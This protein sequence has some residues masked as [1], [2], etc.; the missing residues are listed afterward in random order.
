VQSQTSGHPVE[1]PC[2]PVTNEFLTGKRADVSDSLN[3]PEQ[4]KLYTA[5]WRWHF[6]AGLLAVP[7][8]IFLGVTGAIY[9]FKPVAEPWLYRDLLT[10]EPGDTRLPVEEQLAAVTQ[11]FPESKP[12]SITVGVEPDDATEVG[13]RD[14][15]GQNLLV[16]VNPYSGEVTGSLVRDR[17]LMQQVRNLHGELMMGAFGSAFVE[18]TACWTIILMM[19]GLYLWWPRAGLRWKGLLVPRLRKGSRIL[20]RDLHAITGMYSA[21]VVIVLLITGLPWTNVWGGLFKRAQQ[22]TGQARPVA[23]DFRVPYRSVRPDGAVALT[24][25]EALQIAAG[26]GIAEG[27]TVKLP[28]G[29]EG[30]YGFINRAI[31]PEESDF[32]YLDQYSGKALARANWDDHSV[33]A[34][35]VTLG[36]RLHQGEL[37]GTA[38]LILMLFGAL[39]TVWVS[40]SGGNAVRW[41]NLACPNYRPT[42]VSLAASPS[43]RSFSPSASHS[44]VRR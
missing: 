36:I 6:Y 24:L 28:R 20:W 18:L 10:V 30:T 32:L 39:A 37:F 19:T 31:N 38:N 44:L 4:H 9:L 2:Q 16:Y 17:M 26:Q 3:K 34:K 43:S 41:E 35:A 22:A 8:C 33:S 21:A 13:L 14:K 23:A 5:M 12:D 1:F 42:G 27:S 29:P 7:I 25:S 15:T 11:A 40:S